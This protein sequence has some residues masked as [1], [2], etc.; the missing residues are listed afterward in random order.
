MNI[1]FNVKVLVIDDEE[2][3]RENILDI[4]TP[5]KVLQYDV[6]DAASLLFDEPAEPTLPNISNIPQFEVH[7]ASSGKEGFELV[8]TSLQ[9]DAPYAVIFC[10]M[11]MPGWDG[12]ETIMEIR[13]LDPLVEIIFITAYSDRGI[14]EIVDKA[15]HNVGYH[16]KPFA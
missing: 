16:C 3:V 13:K 4:L 14:H 15:G 2:I 1:M 5:K 12:L 6:T 11:R 7:T 10:D 9:Q 8:K